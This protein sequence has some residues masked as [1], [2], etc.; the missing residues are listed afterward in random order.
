MRDNE[1]H[2]LRLDQTVLVPYKEKHVGRYHDWMQDE[3]LRGAHAG[4]GRKYGNGGGL[5][6]YSSMLE[7]T[8]GKVGRWDGKRW[9]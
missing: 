9:V 8:V 4:R 5:Q 3:W 1:N 6:R 2:K 7:S